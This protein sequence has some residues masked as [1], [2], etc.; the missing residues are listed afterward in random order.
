MKRKLMVA[1]VVM[2][3]LGNTHI[4]T[5]A[6]TMTVN[7][8]NKQVKPNFNANDIRGVAGITSQ[9]LRNATPQTMNEICND[10]VYYSN[11][12]GV[13]ALAVASIIRLESAN[14]TSRLATTKNNLGGITD[15][16]GKYRSFD[17]KTQCI[18]Y[19]VRLLK[20]QYLDPQGKFYRGYSLRNINELYCPNDK[21][22]WSKKVSS[23]AKTMLSNIQKS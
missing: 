14:N 9:Q 13:N 19:M 20:T 18:E 2:S 23:M 22:D 7:V 10:I 5:Q 21:Y 3:V 17:S 6:N 15:G 16:N 11:A 4:T 8:E 1:M 12:Y